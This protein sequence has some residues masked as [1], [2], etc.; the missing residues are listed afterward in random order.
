MTKLRS[1]LAVLAALYILLSP[2]W[3]QVLG[4]PKGPVRAW[5][6]FRGYGAGIC[7]V[8]YETEE[9]DGE[10]VPFD[11]YA[12]LHKTRETAH[13]K[14]KL[15]LGMDAVRSMTRK[16]CRRVPTGRPLYVTA[17]CATKT[18]WK[19]TARGKKDQC[20][21]TPSAPALHVP[22]ARP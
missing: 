10:R 4:N 22:K 15:L 14:E 5:T 20:E 9:A 3:H 17:K 18:G 1:C 21:G 7:V 6:M 11:R 16:L 8:A 13:D 12:A 19:D 2:A